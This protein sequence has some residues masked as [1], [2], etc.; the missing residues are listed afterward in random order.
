MSKLVVIL[1]IVGFIWGIARIAKLYDKVDD[2]L[3]LKEENG[4]APAPQI[5]AAD[6]AP[7][8]PAVEASLAQAK[9]NGPAALKAW[10]DGYGARVPE[11]RKS[12]IELDYAQLLVLSNPA[13]ARRVFQAVKA[14]TPPNSV[15]APRVKKLARTF[16]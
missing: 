14:R 4:S 6:L 2:H 8:A 15:I 3:N 13:E 7:L 10:L 5:T 9:A 1:L 11:P 12:D 16:E